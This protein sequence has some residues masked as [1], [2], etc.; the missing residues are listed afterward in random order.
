MFDNS[1]LLDFSPRDMTISPTNSK[2]LKTKLQITRPSI[3][4][5]LMMLFV[6]NVLELN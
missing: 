2:R 4:T 3:K 1:I 5:F 6:A